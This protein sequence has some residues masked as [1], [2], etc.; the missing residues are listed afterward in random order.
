[1]SSPSG[2][3][4]RVMMISAKRLRSSVC[5]RPAASASSVLPVPA[6]PRIVT[7]SI[8][9]SISRLSAKFCSRLRAVMPQTLWRSLRKS[10]TSSS[11][12]APLFIRRTMR[13]D[14]GRAILVART[15]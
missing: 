9:G 1:M 14:A 13:L 7:Q 5:S 10:R 4:T 2:M 3:V 8:S 6:G 11:V 15:R 12:A